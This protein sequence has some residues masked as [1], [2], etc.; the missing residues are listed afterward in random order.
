M[1]PP[2]EIEANALDIQPL[3]VAASQ[4]LDLPSPAT[5][6][7]LSSFFWIFNQVFGLTP[8]DRCRGHSDTP[9]AGAPAAT[10]DAIERSRTL[11]VRSMVYAL[12]RAHRFGARATPPG[13]PTQRGLDLAFLVL[14][15]LIQFVR[16]VLILDLADLF[17]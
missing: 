15:L 17:R 6:Q 3:F 14:V 5:L 4:S 7:D 2:T 1:N 8:I 16:S 12:L 11:V 9:N 13:H 10:V